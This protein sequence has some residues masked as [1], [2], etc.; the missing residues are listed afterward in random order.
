MR[1][2][3]HIKEIR[4]DPMLPFKTVLFLKL[5]LFF[6]KLMFK[7][8]FSTGNFDI[9]FDSTKMLTGTRC[10]NASWEL[11][12]VLFPFVPRSFTGMALTG[13]IKK[14]RSFIREVQLL[15]HHIWILLY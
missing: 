12:C 14:Q 13:E 9:F 5:S 10:Y 4:A 6:Q 3:I 1:R 11:T 8:I 2:E 15:E 7:S